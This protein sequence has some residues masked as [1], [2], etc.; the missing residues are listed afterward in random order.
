MGRW[1]I[2][3]FAWQYIGAGIIRLL[4]WIVW[5]FRV[6]P[7][8]AEDLPSLPL[9]SAAVASSSSSTSP[10]PQIVDDK[11]T[12]VVAIAASPSVVTPPRAAPKPD[13]LAPES[14]IP[15]RSG[16]EEEME[17]NKKND[18]LRRED[19]MENE[20]PMRDHLQDKNKELLSLP[21]IKPSHLVEEW[22]SAM[23]LDHA[24]SLSPA[25]HSTKKGRKPRVHFSA[26][27]D[28]LEDDE[29]SDDTL[30]LS[31]SAIG[32]TASLPPAIALDH[33]YC[34]PFLP[35]SEPQVISD[36]DGEPQVDP[37]PVR[38]L[39]DSGE[40]LM[41]EDVPNILMEV[42]VV[43]EKPVEEEIPVTRK[44]KRLSDVTNFP[45]SRELANILPPVVRKPEYCP[46]GQK[47]ETELLQEYLRKGLDAEDMAYLKRQY[48]ELVQ[49]DYPRTYWVNETHWVNHPPTFELSPPRK[50]SRT[51][52]YHDAIDHHQHVTGNL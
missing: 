8:E 28:D 32:L 51:S 2:R 7:D 42:D 33:N 1:Q 36:S 35:V 37:L 24:Y 43:E 30:S 18:S 34:H 38:I 6:L 25:L 45:G 19:S 47:E 16:R 10:S 41:T 44:R 3:W 27:E 5:S 50:R 23:V 22:L 26:R 21:T 48:D 49:E 17:T 13:S 52:R 40:V 46:R 14:V 12:P 20:Q 15:D 11:R 29:L 31:D 9:P 4:T 39:T